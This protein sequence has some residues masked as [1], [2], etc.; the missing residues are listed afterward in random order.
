VFCSDVPGV[1]ADPKDPSTL[2]SSLTDVE[3]RRLIAN[4]TIRD[5]MVPKVESCLGALDSGVR[6]IHIVDAG[7]PH[8]LL[9]EIFTAE[10]I[11]TELHLAPRA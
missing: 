9:L 10:G 4:G 1:C 6:K 11:G 7:V 5:G 8:A 3:A 2:I